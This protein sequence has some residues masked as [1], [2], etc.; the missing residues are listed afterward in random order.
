MFLINTGC[1]TIGSFGKKCQ[2]SVKEVSR[3]V[4]SHEI[5]CYLQEIMSKKRIYTYTVLIVL[6]II[7]W[8]LS[9]SDKKNEAFTERVKISLREVGNQ[10]L[11][12]NQDSTSLILPVKKISDYK[13]QVSFNEQLSFEPNNLVTIIDSTLNISQLPKHYRVEV[14]Q[15][16]DQEVAYS[17]QMSKEEESTIIPCNG[18]YL[19]NG[20]YTIEVTFFK[21]VTSFFNRKNL[22]YLLL[23]IIILFI[24]DSF[25]SKR[26][27]KIVSEND[28]KKY[29]SIGR[30]RFYPEQNK[31]VKEAEEISLS[32][33][34]CELLEIFVAHP[35]QII[36]RDE[37]TKKVWEDNG[38]FVGRSLDT[39]ISKLRK[40]LKDD[41]AIKLTNVHGVGYK[42]EVS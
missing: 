38:V 29:T 8:L 3:V 31:L 15:C 11:L 36:K 27:R 10:L 2:K 1:K 14:L 17:Y 4:K 26:K 37:L 25:Y 21:R 16:L 20:C 28:H 40:K 5:V 35:N 33:K 24:I 18:R 30:F 13:Y 39:Y 19:P 32:K 6:V 41:D 7:G 34:E 9:N 12:S 23:S 42:L 22:F